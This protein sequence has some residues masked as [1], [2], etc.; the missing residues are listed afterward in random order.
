MSIPGYKNP[1]AGILRNHIFPVLGGKAC[2]TSGNKSLSTNRSK[3]INTNNYYMT[4][5]KNED[6]IKPGTG[7]S[8]HQCLL[9]HNIYIDLHEM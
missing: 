9:P 1:F 7:N 2:G 4:Q 8:G 5:L 6:D 3:N